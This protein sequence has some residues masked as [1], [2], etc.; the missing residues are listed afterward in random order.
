MPYPSSIQVFTSL[1]CRRDRKDGDPESSVVS[2]TQALNE[3]IQPSS[4]ASQQ[5]ARDNSQ[6]RR[7]TVIDEN[8]PYL[9]VPER[10]RDSNNR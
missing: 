10:N 4:S 6:R 1:K 5:T 7:P 9:Y 8:S 2:S 3:V